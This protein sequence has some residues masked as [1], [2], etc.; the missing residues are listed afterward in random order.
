MR[1]PSSLLAVLAAGVA[2]A[3]AIPSAGAQR[4]AHAA[5]HTPQPTR[6]ITLSPAVG[7]IAMAVISFPHAAR[8]AH[9]ERAPFSVLAGAPFGDD[10]LVSGVVRA[11]GA[12]E[13]RALVL[14]VNR[15]TALADPS[16]V[17]VRASAAASLGKPQILE[18]LDPFTRRPAKSATLC[19]VTP[20]GQALAAGEL[21]ALG[22]RG[23]ALAGFSPAAAL[24]EG[25][26]AV[27]GLPYTSAFK[28]D[29]APSSPSASPP[30]ATPPEVKATRCMP[31]KP[32]G[33][34][35]CPV[36]LSACL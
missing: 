23:G 4:P 36:A 25:Y 20:A 10:Y 16:H 19:A 34:G 8:G 33:S 7:D 11:A 14:L 32:V 18:A 17:S 21:T 3:V 28:Q 27:C 2:L 22:T 24:A 31:C 13:P 35:A 30:S 1:V 6:R 9:L 29:I 5:G 15:A 26:D 12:K